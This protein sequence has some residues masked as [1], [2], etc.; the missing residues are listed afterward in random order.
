MNEPSSPSDRLN[1]A[2]IVGILNKHSSHPSSF[3]AMNRETLCFTRP[4]IEGLIAYRF[5]G[6]QYVVMVAGIHCALSDKAAL[7]AAFLHWADRHH[8]RVIAVQFHKEDVLL[9][10]KYGFKINQLGASYCLS[11]ADYK[12]AGTPFMKLRNKISRARRAGIE[13]KELGRD[14]PY[15]TDLQICVDDINRD[16]IKQKKA[17]ELQF[18]ISDA[19]LLDKLD[20]ARQRIFFAFQD[21]KPLAFILYVR[22]FGTFQGWM[23]ELTRKFAQTPPGVMEL[24]NVTALQQF[25]AEGGT[26]L[27]FGFTPLTSLDERY[28]IAEAKNKTMS[29]IF[30]FLYQHGDVIYPAKSQYAYKEKWQPDIVLPEYIAFGPGAGLGALWQFLKLVRA[31]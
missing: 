26:Y 22:T 30:K 18:L 23:H 24:I 25:S 15:S 8:Y 11:L 10:K 7:L 21:G 14:L 31:I 9:L 3:L 5:A 19:P 6:K 12:M 17:K 13:I 27:N 1:K 20:T 28:E 29:R 16:W 2:E 4:E